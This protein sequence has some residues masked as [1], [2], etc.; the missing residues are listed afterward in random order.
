[1]ETQNLLE[2]QSNI[3][4]NI[5]PEW[6][7][8]IYK[9]E[10]KLML[11]VI[12]SQLISDI[13][14]ITPNQEDWFNWCRLTSLNET[15]IVILG[16]DVY[17]TKGHAHGLSFSCLGSVPKSLRNIYQ[18]LLKSN[19]IS[20]MPD[21]GDLSSWAT[22]GVLL[23]NI[24]MTTKIKKAGYHLKLWTAYTQTIIERICLHHYNKGNQLIFFLWGN[25]AKDFKKYID[26]DFHEIL[27][28]IHPSP[29]AQN[30][31][32]PK[33]QKDKFINCNHFTYA[34]KFLKAED[35]ILI[36]WNSINSNM[37]SVITTNTETTNSETTNSETTNTETNI[38]TSEKPK[39]ET[40]TTKKTETEGKEKASYDKI[41]NMNINHHIAFTDGSCFPN[42]K[43]KDSRAGWASV[44]VSGSLNNTLLYGN[45]DISKY[46]ASNIRAEGYAII[47]VM[48]MVQNS[49]KPWKRLTIIT[50]CMF[51]IDMCEKY[52]KKWTPA[53]FASKTNSDLTSQMWY[54]YNKLSKKGEVIFM[55]IKSHNKDGWKNF[56]SG[57]FEKF[58]YDQ[59]DYVDK[60]CGYA[61][62]KLQPTNEI[63]SIR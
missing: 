31:R 43:N 25:F 27:E 11:D 61:R 4:N 58:C 3:L 51:W 38:E 32:D 42:T 10:T 52:M 59:N 21:Q 28:W 56:E 26:G 13:D 17:P 57:T 54:S 45:L 47:R 8:I 2:F 22:Q 49:D 41:L 39:T 6:L 1:M 9:D 60:Q 62:I 16:Q 55:H 20:R 33:R 5:S 34:N 35:A 23:L 46:F 29:L 12:I 19:E 14:E 18:C 48:E 63:T 15:K 44:F 37:V 30:I 36:N 40:E 24:G 53:I 7:N 50:D